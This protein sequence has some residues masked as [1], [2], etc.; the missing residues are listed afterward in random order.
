MSVSNSTSFSLVSLFEPHLLA[1]PYPFYHRLRAEDPV[2]WD[3][4][5]GIWAVTRYASVVAALRDPRISSRRFDGA[6]NELWDPERLPPEARESA[7]TVYRAFTLLSLM[8]DPPEHTRLRRGHTSALV[9]RRVEEMR[10]RIQ[11]PVEEIIDRA[12]PSGRMEVIAELA[13]PLPA[14]VIAELLGVPAEDRDRFKA[15]SDDFATV[16]DADP[17]RPEREAQAVRGVAALLAYVGDLVERRKTEPRDDLTQALIEAMAS[18]DE[19]SKAGVVANLAGLVFAGHETT[20]NLIG[21][22]LLA[23]LRH[24]EQLRRV[25]DDASLVPAAVEELLRYDCPVQWIARRAKE[26]LEIEG[27]RIGAG[28]MIGLF[29]GAANRD[30]AQFAEPDRLDVGR[31]ENRHVAFGHGIHFCLGA[32]LARLEGQVVVETVLRR[33]PDLRLATETQQWRDNVS[34]RG[35]KALPVIFDPC[36]GGAM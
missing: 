1:D 17:N 22:G 25:R 35:L 7:R 4:S 11:R 27:R 23:L 21:N 34:M 36:N 5:L 20:T 19:E 12:Q 24:P 2:H 18:D 32:A 6:T 15:W 13:Y 9:P 29:L 26:D 10:P 33:L 30:P 31:S 14:A 16:F 8:K 3:E 28:Q